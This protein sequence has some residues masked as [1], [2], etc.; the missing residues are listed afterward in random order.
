MLIVT[1]LEGT[2]QYHQRP[3]SSLYPTSCF[4]HSSTASR[5]SKGLRNNPNG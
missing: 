1:L 3:A 5:G 4:L 2:L